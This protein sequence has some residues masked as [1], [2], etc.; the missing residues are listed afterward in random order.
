M[1]SIAHPSL[2]WE[3]LS[4]VKPGLQPR[5]SSHDREGVVLLVGC[6]NFNPWAGSSL[7]W[8]VNKTPSSK[9][10]ETAETRDFTRGKVSKGCQFLNS[11]L[12]PQ[13]Q[14][15]WA[16]Q[17]TAT[18]PLAVSTAAVMVN[19]TSSS[20]PCPGLLLLASSLLLRGLIWRAKGLLLSP[21]TQ[22]L[23]VSGCADVLSLV[24]LL[25]IPI[26]LFLLHLLF[27]AQEIRGWRRQIGWE[28]LT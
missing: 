8:D 25:P 2:P 15:L 16:S 22:L 27:R 13:A 14:Q 5:P 23:G 24:P 28:T 1:R 11:F 7:D 20:L 10:W 18:E 6:S 9:S 4:P 26:Y 17:R 21:L 3:H 12:L 19:Q